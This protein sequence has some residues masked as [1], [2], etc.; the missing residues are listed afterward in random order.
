MGKYVDPAVFIQALAAQGIND[1]F[2]WSDNGPDLPQDHPR[3]AEIIAIWD[4]LPAVPKP[5]PAEPTADDLIAQTGP[6][7][8]AILDVLGIR[9]Q[10][11]NR[12]KAVESKPGVSPPRRKPPQA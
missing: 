5:S 8:S 2:V 1:A 11:S 9:A 6:V 7:V 3:K 12:L 10:V 4:A